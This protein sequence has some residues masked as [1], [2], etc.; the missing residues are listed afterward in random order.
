LPCST[1][2]PNEAAWVGRLSENKRRHLEFERETA[3]RFARLQA[4]RAEII[5]VHSE[6]GRLREH[7]PE[8]IRDPMGFQRPE[9]PNPGAWR[10]LVSAP[11]YCFS[12]NWKFAFDGFAWFVGAVGSLGAL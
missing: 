12:E 4:N 5:P 6:H 7:L 10:R 3:E 9:V 11:V 8:A 2:I 1:L